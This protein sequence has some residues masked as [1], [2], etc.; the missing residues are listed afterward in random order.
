[1]IKK[2]A[3]VLYFLN[4]LIILSNCTLKCDLDIA[5]CPI[6]S[7]QNAIKYYKDS[8]Y[9]ESQHIFII[10]NYK[11]SLVCD[12]I[13][14]KF[15]CQLIDTIS[16]LP[17]STS[18]HFYKKSFHTNQKKLNEFYY[19]TTTY[20]DLH[21]LEYTFTIYLPASRNKDSLIIQEE[22]HFGS[23]YS[24]IQFKLYNCRLNQDEN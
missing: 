4:A 1:M 12:E 15:V 19:H 9:Y 22:K 18:I 23:I 17:T 3:S 24:N 10:N 5:Y 13:V 16:F 7:Y 20:S 8:M 21:D 2:L 14:D 6:P 11:N